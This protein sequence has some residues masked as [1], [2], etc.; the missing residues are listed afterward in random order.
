MRVERDMAEIIVSPLSQ[1][2]S[3]IELR[4]PDHIV[5]LTSG[6][7]PDLPYDTRRLCLTFN[8]I[9]EPRD[10]L[11]V[12]SQV[13]VERLLSFAQEWDQSRPLLI[14][15]YAGISRSTACAYIVALALNRRL[16][17]AALAQKLRKI[18][19]SATPNI[20]LISLADAILGRNGR[21]VAAIQAIGRG[22]EAFEGEAFSLY[23]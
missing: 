8:D 23:L 1:L 14:H 22:T 6:E 15:C 17:E 18:S 13:H 2:N 3:L 19:A 9:V 21:M 11:I 7:I 4:K 12:P 20:R 10:E 5:S 16:Q